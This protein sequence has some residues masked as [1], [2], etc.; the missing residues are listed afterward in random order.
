[1][2]SKTTP[3]M[4]KLTGLLFFC[5]LIACNKTTVNLTPLSSMTI[6]NAVP[7]SP[8]A[9]LA[10]YS[11][12]VYPGSYGQFG[13][14]V[15]SNPLIYVWPTGDSTHPYYNSSLS[16]VNGG[17]YSLYLTGTDPQTNTLLFKDTIP[18]YSDSLMGTRFIN[19]SSD[20][21]PL[22]FDFM[23]TAV[24]PLVSNL[25]YKSITSFKTLPAGSAIINNGGYNF[26]VRDTAGN[27]LFT[28]NQAAVTFKNV[29]IVTSGLVG[30]GSFSAF[31]VNNY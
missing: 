13:L 17:I 15:T 18:S 23:D 10:A 8:G 25:S 26:E 2:P 27:I 6:V 31:T 9:M 14:I 24:H 1:M 21:G 19:L 30:D 7:G 4:T 29:T 16:A 5:A 12:P 11:S 22:T 20:S 28:L 3:A